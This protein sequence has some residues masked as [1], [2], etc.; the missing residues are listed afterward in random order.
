MSG[1]PIVDQTDAAWHSTRGPL[2]TTSGDDEYELVA[3]LASNQV[4]GPT[5]AA[6]DYIKRFAFIPTTTSPG[7]V[8]IKDGSGSAI[9]VFAGGTSSIAD[10]KSWDMELGIASTAGAWSVTTGT[11]ISVLATGN[12]T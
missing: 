2:E 6:G 8:T 5:G 10:L 1:Y 7:A 3:A 4:L 11:A 12:F 9:T